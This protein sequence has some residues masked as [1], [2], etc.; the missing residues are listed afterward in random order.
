MATAFFL[1]AAVLFLRMFLDKSDPESEKRSI[2][3]VIFAAIMAYLFYKLINR[4][5][6]QAMVLP[7]ANAMHEKWGNEKPLRVNGAPSFEPQL[8]RF[9]DSGL[10]LDDARSALANLY[11]R[12]GQ[13]VRQ[14]A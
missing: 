4:K 7:R 5:K 14:V 9:M 1:V 12:E 2:G 8:Q 6:A 10:S 13:R 11:K 3:F